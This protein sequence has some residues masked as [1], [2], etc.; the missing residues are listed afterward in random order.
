MWQ[1]KSS[2]RTPRTRSSPPTPRKSSPSKKQ[3]KPLQTQ[4]SFRATRPQGSLARPKPCA[5]KGRRLLHHLRPRVLRSGC[6]PLSR[7]TKRKDRRLQYEPRDQKS[8]SGPRLCRCE[9]RMVERGRGIIDGNDDAPS[10][11]S[12]TNMRCLCCCRC[13]PARRSLG[14]GGTRPHLRRRSHARTFSFPSRAGRERARESALDS[15]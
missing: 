5:K 11:A 10:R 14:A 3:N 8:E 4:A 2:L 1:S 13:A 9:V 12:P 6:N 15:G 7:E